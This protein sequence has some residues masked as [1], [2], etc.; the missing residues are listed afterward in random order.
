MFR[1]AILFERR[2]AELSLSKTFTS[3]DSQYSKFDVLYRMQRD[4]EYGILKKISNEKKLLLSVV[5][6]LPTE[7]TYLASLKRFSFTSYFIVT[8]EKK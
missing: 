7:K 6:S 3:V 5:K 2:V 1:L 4:D 8:Q